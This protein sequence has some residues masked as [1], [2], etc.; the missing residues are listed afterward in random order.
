MARLKALCPLVKRDYLAKS[1][2]TSFWGIC[3][4]EEAVRARE[5]REEEARVKSPGSN[6]PRPKKEEEK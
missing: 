5:A 1:R 3:P 4:D 6:L 2:R